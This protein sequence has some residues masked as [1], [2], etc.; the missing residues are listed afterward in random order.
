MAQQWH[1]LDCITSTLTTGTSTQYLPGGNCSVLGVLSEGMWCMMPRHTVLVGAL[2]SMLPAHTKDVVMLFGS[3]SV[4]M[5][6]ALR[7]VVLLCLLAAVGV[8][9]FDVGAM[10]AEAGG[11]QRCGW[12]VWCGSS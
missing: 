3:V 1:S 2:W 9:L 6:C 10:L 7:V 12:A 5:L 8:S 4:A 11:L